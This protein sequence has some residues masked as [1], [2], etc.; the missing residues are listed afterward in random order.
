MCTRM[1][2]APEGHGEY[3]PLCTRMH[4][5]PEGHGEYTA[6]RERERECVCVHGAHM[7]GRR[8]AALPVSGSRI[9]AGV[10]FRANGRQPPLNVCKQS[11]SFGTIS[12]SHLTWAMSP[13]LRTYERCVRERCIRD[14]LRETTSGRREKGGGGAVTFTSQCAAIGPVQLQG[15]IIVCCNNST[16]PIFQGRHLPCCCTKGRRQAALES[17]YRMGV[18]V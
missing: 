6:E 15:G 9:I 16:I 17:R 4:Y 13:L 10:S 18:Y 8:G 3:T 5:A 2:Y 7:R 1:H 12:V 11:S 14:R